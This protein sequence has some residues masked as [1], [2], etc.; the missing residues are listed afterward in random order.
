MR[1]WKQRFI[2]W[3]SQSL[4][5]RCGILLRTRVAI[6]PSQVITKINLGATIFFL[7]SIS[8]LSG[9]SINWSLSQPYKDDHN[10][11]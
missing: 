8:H 10:Q 4:P 11:D 3:F 9:I 7:V 5:P 2:P 1:Q 6:N